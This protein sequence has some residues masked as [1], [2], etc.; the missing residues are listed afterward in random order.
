MQEL[1]LAG[2]SLPGT[3]RGTQR[4]AQAQAAAAAAAAAGAGPAE[5]GGQAGPERNGSLLL[6]AAKSE[7]TKDCDECGS[8]GGGGPL[9]PWEEGHRWPWQQQQQ[10]QAGGKGDGCS[11]KGRG[12][13]GEVVS[14]PP[15]EAFEAGRWLCFGLHFMEACYECLGRGKG[16]GECALVR[17]YCPRP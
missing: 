6:V 2:Q 12:R 17:R 9:F 14:Y 8:S 4:G 16:P 5:G 7:K 13:R 1:V 15:V 11:A 3:Q 10:Q